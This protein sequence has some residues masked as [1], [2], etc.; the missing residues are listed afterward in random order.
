MDADPIESALAG[1]DVLVTG[2]A[3]FIGSHLVEGLLRYDVRQ[4]RVLDNFAN[5]KRDNLTAVA[6]DPRLIVQEAS[7]L[8]AQAVADAC[9]GAPL[10]FHLACL[11]V[12]HS[13][14]SPLLNH[15][16]NAEGTL[17]VLEA[18]RLAGVRRFV[19]VSTSEVYGTARHAPMNEEHPT[20]PMTVYGGGKLAG[21]SY[22]RAYFETYGFPTV[23]VRPFNNF[24]PRSHF[25]GD[26]GE[27]IPRFLT[28]ALAGLP[29]V[30]FGDGSQTRDFIFV[31]DTV[32]ALLLLAADDRCVGQTLN[33]GRGSEITVHELAERILQATG[34]TELRPE[35][36]PPRPGDVLRLCADTSKLRALTGFQPKVSFADGLAQVVA[37]FR[38]QAD[39]REAAPQPVRNW[40]SPL[41]A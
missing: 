36:E 39:A 8:D 21:E 23:M 28:R 3:G 40:I 16:V 41:A 33:V 37:W 9:R 29:P 2:G 12:R 32:R 5:G 27:V 18:A 25:E 34:R 38:S 22:A 11:G 19:Y 15:R 35:H 31:T 4:V 24:G 20:R 1:K 30:I 7:I 6:H 10:V 17:R 13:L 14:H 26:A